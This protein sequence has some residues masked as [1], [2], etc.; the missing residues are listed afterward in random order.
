MKVELIKVTRCMHTLHTQRVHASKRIY[1]TD[2]VERV[3][4]ST[5]PEDVILSDVEVAQN[6]AGGIA[7]CGGS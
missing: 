2:E 1:D 4:R 5:P 6:L 3:R 7:A